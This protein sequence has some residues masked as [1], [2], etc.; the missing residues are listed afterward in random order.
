[1][2]EHDGGRQ[3]RGDGGGELTLR[4][5][6]VRS[7]I[8]S[9]RR[10]YKRRIVP[11]PGGRGGGFRLRVVRRFLRCEVLAVL[12]LLLLSALLHGGRDGGRNASPPSASAPRARCPR[13]LLPPA[14]FFLFGFFFN[15]RRS[16]S[17]GPPVG[18]RLSL[19]PPRCGR[20]VA[21]QR[22]KQQPGR[23]TERE[24]EGEEARGRW[25]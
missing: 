14:S 13:L 7:F 6:A 24:R 12:L 25:Y 3:G 20:S 9:P 5:S 2:C 8:V 21:P 11:G 22:A 4:S 23:K 16:A 19:L 10:C 17:A 1:M 15:V 18:P